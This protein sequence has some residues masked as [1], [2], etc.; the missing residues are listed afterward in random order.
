MFFYDIDLEEYAKQ[1][2]L[3]VNRLKSTNN[4]SKKNKNN[5]PK[6]IKGDYDLSIHGNKILLVDKNEGTMVETKCHPDDNFN[7]G[8]GVEEAFRKLNT[9]REDIKKQKE[10]EDKKIKVGDWVEIIRPS[11]AYPMY[12]DFF[13]KNN[14]NYYGKIFRY[15]TIAEKG[16]VG[17][18]VFVLNDYV[19]VKSKENFNGYGK[20][21][22]TY[23]VSFSAI[24]KVTNLL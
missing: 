17:K 11:A 21:D 10:E 1:I 16:T 5:A 8:I 7:I 4:F 12:A 14:L 18:V 23:L 22:C 19:V 20:M 3:F 9:K 13:E 24:R 2:D 15:G 6:N